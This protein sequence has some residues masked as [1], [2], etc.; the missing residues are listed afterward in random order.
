ME[1]I[2]EGEESA[3]GASD[4]VEMLRLSF[5]R[6]RI[7]ILLG[8]ARATRLDKRPERLELDRVLP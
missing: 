3:E 5:E 4:S 8:N 6:P 2:V 7:R 1:E